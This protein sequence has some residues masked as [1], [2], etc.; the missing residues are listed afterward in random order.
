ME[1]LQ[2]RI[3]SKVKSLFL[4]EK[5]KSVWKVQA[6]DKI[7][8][9]NLLCL[10]QF[11]YL[12]YLFILKKYTSHIFLLFNQRKIFLKVW[13]RN[14]LYPS[15]W[16]TLCWSSIWYLPEGFSRV[17]WLNMACVI[18]WP[19]NCLHEMLTPLY[20]LLK[21]CCHTS[22]G[23]QASFQKPLCSAIGYLAGWEVWA[24]DRDWGVTMVAMVDTVMVV[25][26]GL[27][28]SAGR[29]REPWRQSSQTVALERQVEKG[30]P[31][32][33]L[34]SSWKLGGLCHGG[35]GG[36][37]QCEVFSCHEGCIVTTQPRTLL[38]LDLYP[39]A[40]GV[41]FIKHERKDCISWKIKGTQRW[42]RC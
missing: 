36:Q 5:K 40:L 8:S 2:M 19:E 37:G 4:R 14:W 42:G 41:L 30:T 39:R 13:R 33:S 9:L 25:S 11:L 10:V 20:T 31:L 35:Q 15:S 3:N 21:A 1:S 6:E 18:C 23:L 24:R 29:E 26:M 32:R 28:E 38:V 34:R 17:I 16:K 22:S 27:P 12:I 7:V